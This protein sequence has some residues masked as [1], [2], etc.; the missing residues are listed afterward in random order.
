M[1]AAQ[2]AEYRRAV[3]DL[4]TFAIRDLNNALISLEGASPVVV[5]D[6]LIAAFPELVGPYI[7]ASGDLTATWYEE[8][9][10]AA[11]GGTFYATSSGA[12]NRAQV[13]ALVRWGVR[14]L[15]GRSGSTV[16][17]L[18]GGGVQR[19]IAGAGRDTIFG[20]VR[21]DRVKVG[22]ARIPKSG[23]CAFCA[24]LASR[25]AVYHSE[26]S[27]GSQGLGDRFHD[28]C[29]CV[30]TPVFTGDTIAEETAE[31]YMDMYPGVGSGGTKGALADMRE[32]YDI[33]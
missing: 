5:R 27:G 1:T 30:V 6:T 28:Y 22:Y 12:V 29:R 8:L 3:D 7:T 32:T 15:L 13:D 31:K 16:L 10:R 23:C 21:R 33:K 18:V 20:N 4:S 26:G 25:G 14:P 19:M 17:S 2:V 11:I 24:L 9:R